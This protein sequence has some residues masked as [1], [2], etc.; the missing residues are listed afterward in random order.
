MLV[1]GDEEGKPEGGISREKESISTIKSILHSIKHSEDAVDSTKSKV[2][3]E[4]ADTC[5]NVSMP[6]ILRFKLLSLSASGIYA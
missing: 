1:H 3:E 2:R 4:K 5:L 6:V